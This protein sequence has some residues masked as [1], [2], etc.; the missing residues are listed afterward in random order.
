MTATA[1]INVSAWPG[2]MSVD[3]AA[4]Y[5][6]FTER[7]FKR[8]VGAGELPQPVLL[9]GKERWRLVDIE[10]AFKENDEWEMSD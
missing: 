7:E 5:C 8:A 1:R 9:N 10:T 2:L 4:A 3:I 6:C